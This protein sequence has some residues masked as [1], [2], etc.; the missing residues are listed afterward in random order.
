MLER[1]NPYLL[2]VPSFSRSFQNRPDS[3]WCQ[4]H[5]STEDPSVKMLSWHMCMNMLMEYAKICSHTASFWEIVSVTA[6]QSS[7]SFTQEVQ[8]T[9]IS[10]ADSCVIPSQIAAFLDVAVPPSGSRSTLKGQWNS[11]RISSQIFSWLCFLSGCGPTK[12]LITD[13]FKSCPGSTHSTWSSHLLF[14]CFLHLTFLF[15]VG[16][17]QNKNICNNNTKNHLG[18]KV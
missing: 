6:H 4:R 8:H 7:I 13:I 11:I 12:A 16:K 9:N 15:Q 17:Q 2:S 18:C 5:C 10:W 3:A 1:R 14:A